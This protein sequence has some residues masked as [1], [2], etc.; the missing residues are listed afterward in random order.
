MLLRSLEV[1][2]F[3]TRRPLGSI[4]WWYRTGQ[5][6][7]TACDVRT[8]RVLVDVGEVRVLA[9]SRGRRRRDA[10]IVGEAD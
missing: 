4:R 6:T 2:A 8:R 3:L 10:V 7:G 5:I 1:A 9:E